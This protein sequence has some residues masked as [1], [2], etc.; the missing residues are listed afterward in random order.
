MRRLTLFTM[1]LLAAL[2]LAARAK[3]D[4]HP[5]NY[6]FGAAR[7]GA[8]AVEPIREQ[9]SVAWTRALDGRPASPSRSA[10]PVGIEPT[11]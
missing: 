1:L 2:T 8:S 7:T 9:P 11:I 4:P 5:V 3:F 10:R 6:R